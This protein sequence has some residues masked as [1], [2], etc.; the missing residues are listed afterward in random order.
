MEGHRERH[1]AP[2][3]HENEV[4]GQWTYT[5]GLNFGLSC[6]ELWVGHRTVSWTQGT[7]VGSFQLKISYDS[8]SSNLLFS[9]VLFFLS[10]QW[11]GSF[12]MKRINKNLFEATLKNS[13]P[14]QVSV[15]TCSASAQIT[16]RVCSISLQQCAVG[17]NAKGRDKSRSSLTDPELHHPHT[18]WSRLC[19]WTQR[20]KGKHWF[21]D[22]FQ[23]IIVQRK[24]C[25]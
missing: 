12:W 16:C 5:Q 13:F 23:R 15:F 9:Q 14:F 1:T 3:I 11:W 22:V 17:R 6:V 7:L 4:F 8:M 24:R 2:K 10:F 21:L 20:K 18:Q 25:E 19:C